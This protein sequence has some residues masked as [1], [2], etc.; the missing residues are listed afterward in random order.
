MAGEGRARKEMLT[1]MVPAGCLKVLGP[2]VLPFALL[3]LSLTPAR[4][5]SVLQAA[6]DSCSLLM[7]HLPCPGAP[8]MV[9]RSCSAERG[10]SSASV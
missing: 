4:A 1:H 7:H 6:R 3:S 8:Q 10:G 2:S 5:P 9:P